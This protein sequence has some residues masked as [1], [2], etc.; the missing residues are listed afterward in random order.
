[1]QFRVGINF[2][3]VVIE[4]DNLYGEGVNI[5][6][7]LEALAQPGGICLSKNVHEIVNKKTG[8]E[9][10]DL[11]EQKVKNTVLHAVDVKLDGTT[12]RK[13]SQTQKISQTAPWKKYTA[14]FILAAIIAGGGVWWWQRPD[15]QPADQSKFSFKLPEK[16]SIAVL[17]FN[18]L[19]GD[20]AQDYLGD[21]LTENIIAVL[22]TSPDLFVIA[23][24]SSFTYR[25]KAVKVQEVAEQL[26][27]RYVLEGS[28]QQSGEK[29]RI[30]AQLVDALD[31]KHL[32]AE[33]YD[34][35]LDDLFAVQDEI[36][37]KIFEAMQVQ[38][39]IGEQARDWKKHL[40][41]PDEM[42]LTIQGLQRFLTYSPQG[43]KDA[44]RLW[45]EVFENNPEIGMGN[46]MM[47]WLHFQK[48]V[49]GWTKNP[50]QNIALA[51]QFS[52]KAHS[53]MGD[54]N[55]LTLLALLD[56]M[57]SN[58]KGAIE[59]AERAVEIDP[60]AGDATALAGGT[61]LQ[62]G[63]PKKAAALFRLA[64]RLQP[65][66]PKW[67][68]NGLGKSLMAHGKYDEAEEVLSAIIK[69]DTKNVHERIKALTRLT[70]T[71]VF[72]EDFENAKDYLKRLKKL[73]PNFSIE[74]AKANDL[75]RGKMA[76]QEFV[77]RYVDALQQLGVPEKS[78]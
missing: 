66:H 1:M 38:L 41:S 32:W 75:S 36:T 44:E 53:I 39:T 16:P 24:N 28:V 37:E 18:N 63:R 64:I 71:S 26:G 11:G 23:R 15:F 68:P 40:G 10:H 76:D 31:G 3:D 14:V 57:T 65:Y 25:G 2:G 20:S 62:C 52:E 13:L 33:R 77:R 22:A 48:I 35:M 78:E 72:K 47:G 67:M 58:C 19:S 74:T 21:G 30:T 7:R 34:R 49:M 29:L 70:V 8:F 46:L 17:P 50:K 54:G 6:A 56:A 42:R 60:S 4:D 59:K 73:A 51:R 61:L 43:H 5:A 12:Q 27:V 45:G 9:F 69:S 55:S